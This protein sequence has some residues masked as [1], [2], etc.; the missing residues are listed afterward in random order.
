MNIIY[1]IESRLW[2]VFT[3]CY[4][5]QI[6][7]M[8][9]M[10][11]FKRSLSERF[12][13][14]DPVMHKIAVVISARNESAVIGQLIESIHAQTYPAELI[15]IY[16]CA[17]N[18]TDDTAEVARAAGA[19][20]FER[21][22][23]NL[24]GKGYALDYMFKKILSSDDDSDAFIVFDADNLIDREYITEMN[25]TFGLG[26]EAITSYRNSKNYGTNWISAGYSLWFLREAKYLNNARLELNTS[27]AIS[28]TG[29]LLSRKLVEENGGWKHHLLTEDVEFSVDSVIQGK[30]I[31]YCSTAMLYDE[32]PITFRQSWR[33]RMRWSRGYL[34]VLRRYGLKLCGGMFKGS[35][36]C[37]DMSMNILPAFVFSVLSCVTNVTLITMQLFEGANGAA[38]L[39]LLQMLSSMY[40]TLFLI[41]AIT[42]ATQ[43]K[44][45]HT[46]AWKKILYA[47]TFPVFM[48]TYVPISIAAIFTKVQ[49][50]P[51]QHSI[52]AKQ[53][54]A[55]LIHR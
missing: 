14:R 25:K 46:A 24:V 34:Q 3:I 23:R 8:V 38:L 5:Y 18:C 20:V 36:S 53:V 39:S 49:W 10:L 50:K 26:F 51:I 32:Q 27:C 47:F 35:F 19:T 41:G 30:K 9:Y 6:F 21:Q 52:T 22:N 40:L 12:I 42:T 45:I 48:F 44:K 28:G 37:Y 11:L 1:A 7:Y 55:D 13:N 16:V 31:G 33:Q 17:D 4:S 15:R 29:F 43:W 2:I 54:A